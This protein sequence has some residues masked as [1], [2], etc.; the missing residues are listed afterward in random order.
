[1]SLESSQAFFIKLQTN[2]EF[3]DTLDK[4]NGNARKKLIE[5]AGFDFTDAELRQVI[6]DVDNAEIAGKANGDVWRNSCCTL[7]R[8]IRSW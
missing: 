4:E 5:K 1:M 6:S 8:S 2:R 7:T 3:A